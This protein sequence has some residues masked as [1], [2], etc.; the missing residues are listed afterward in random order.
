MPEPLR[1]IS[2]V[3]RAGA[4]GQ[5][6]V[7]H[8][9]G[10]AVRDG[11]AAGLQTAGGARHRRASRRAAA[12]SRVPQA[13]GAAA[14]V[15]H[16]QRQR[17]P[18]GGAAELDERA[19]RRASRS[20]SSAGAPD[21]HGRRRRRART[22]RSANGTTRSSRCSAS[23]TETPRSCTS[24]VSVASTSSAAVGSSAE[25]GSSSTST[26]G[27]MVSTE[28][29]ATRCCS[30]ARERAQVPGAQVGDAEQV[31]GLLDPAAHGVGRQAE[32]LHAVGELLLDGVGDEAGG[33]VLADVPDEVGALARRGAD[34]AGAVEQHV[35]GRGG[36]RE[37]RGHQP[38]EHAEQRR[39]AR[40]GRPGDQHQLALADGQVD[41]VED[42]ESS[43]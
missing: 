38:G 24:R 32:L 6:D 11:H 34:D 9:D 1:P 16:G 25:V 17:V 15:A 22:I 28:P 8:R 2:A 10:R 43:S 5:V 29:I 21:A 18:A 37:N 27:C 4:E 33:R 7:A 41:A 40:P 35:A 20:S 26:R 42:G 12:P 13:V 30:P 36:R 14:G 31:E 23:S 39:L 3:T 19:G